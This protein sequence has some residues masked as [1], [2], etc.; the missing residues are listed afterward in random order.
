M[1]H[2]TRDYATHLRSQGYR[3]TPQR[4]LILDTL[5]GLG[6]HATIGVLYEHVQLAAPEIDRATVYRTI[7]LFRELGLVNSAEI[8][9]QT[10][11]EVADDIPH[12][13]LICRICGHVADFDHAQLR[14]FVAH[15]HATYG[16]HAEPDHLTINGVC[17]PCAATNNQI[18]DGER[19]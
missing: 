10:T 5:C 19:N 3:V 2:D 14:D 18:S 6:T 16:F 9:N 8:D 17:A 12:H 11:Y 15:L 1:S 4:A 7:N 13:H